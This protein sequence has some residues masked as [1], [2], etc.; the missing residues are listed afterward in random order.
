MSDELN[1]WLDY[2]RMYHVKEEEQ[3]DMQRH[4]IDLTTTHPADDNALI[5]L[6][7]QLSL[8]LT[9]ILLL[10]STPMKP[11]KKPSAKP[12]QML[13]GKYLPSYSLQFQTTRFLL[14]T[15]MVLYQNVC[16]FLYELFIKAKSRTPHPPVFNASNF[17][18]HAS[19]TF[20]F[21]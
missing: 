16:V 6:S 15:P 19:K 21:S 17:L 10:S 12:E 11:S 3:T 8:L 9:S 1:S 4:A 20:N 7:G 18:T 14:L 2:L 13:K 5:L